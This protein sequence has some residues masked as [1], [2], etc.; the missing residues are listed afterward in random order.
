LRLEKEK[1]DYTF[2]AIFSIKQYIA[3]FYDG[4]MKDT[5]DV[6]VNDGS[7][8]YAPGS[9][10][11]PSLDDSGLSLEMT[12]AHTGWRKLNINETVSDVTAG[13]VAT[14]LSKGLLISGYTRFAPLFKE[15]SVYD[16]VLDT[17][18]FDITDSGSS[19]SIAL[20]DGV[21]LSGK[22][23][24][25]ISVNGK[26]ITEVTSYGFRTGTKETG[27]ITHIF[28]E[29]G[30]RKIE[31]IGTYA[32][33]DM[34]NLVYFEMPSSVVNV[35]SYAFNGCRQLFNFSEITQTYFD[36]WFSHLTDIGSYA[37]IN[38][39][40]VLPDLYLPGC[41]KYLGS[42]AFSGIKTIKNVTFGGLGDESK[43]VADDTGDSV[44]LL[45]DLESITYYSTKSESVWDE[46][47]GKFK[48]SSCQTINRLTP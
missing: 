45:I 9:A 11:V 6:I 16:N 24:L 35:D 10:F 42:R 43:L 4:N 22:I 17:S 14:D 8:L 25:P 33:K 38:C 48:Y 29:K 39:S 32:F 28:W 19:V 31:K 37:F 18:M 46:I 15:A 3:R 44:F 13:G 34:T 7:P 27:D 2:Y 23:T 30:D 5:Y 20:K 40:Y 12:Y 47:L 21:K 41:L 26:S 36:D 1:K